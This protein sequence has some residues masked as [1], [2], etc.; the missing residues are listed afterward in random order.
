VAVVTARLLPG[1]SWYMLTGALAG[2][3]LGALRD[4]RAKGRPR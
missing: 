1:T 4:A 3:L 2:S